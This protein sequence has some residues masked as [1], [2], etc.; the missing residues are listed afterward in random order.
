M[1]T[2]LKTLV[3]GAAAFTLSTATASAVVVN[4]NGTAYDVTTK[5]DTF[6][7]LNDANIVDGSRLEEQ[8]WW[9]SDDVARTFAALVGDTFG[10][11]NTFFA[12]NANEFRASGCY[13]VQLPPQFSNTS[14]NTGLGLGSVTSYAVARAVAPVPLPAGGLL[15]LTSLGAA[16][17]LGCIRERRNR[18]KAAA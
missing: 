1:K 2:F 15:L 17:G 4:Y 10:V 8:V 13:L 14:C 12:Y 9:G 6:V 3:V 18:G 7:A 11:Q 16:A 5:T